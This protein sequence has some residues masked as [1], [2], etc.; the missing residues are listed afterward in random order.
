M[1]LGGRVPMESGKIMTK[2]T[3]Q[4]NTSRIYQK[5]TKQ[6][7]LRALEPSPI[8]A[9]RNKRQTPPNGDDLRNL[10]A[11]TTAPSSALKP[12]SSTPELKM[13]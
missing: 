1:F 12:L 9:E 8:V 13:A 4:L 5:Q 6:M 3:I 2:P 11:N 7:M 10:T